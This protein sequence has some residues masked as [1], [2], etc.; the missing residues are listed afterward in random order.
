[1]RAIIH[2]QVQS[3]DK[4]AAIGGTALVCV[5]R[6]ICA[7][8]ISHTV[9]PDQAVAGHL[10]INSRGG[11][12]HRQMQSNDRVAAIGG[13][14]LVCIC[15]SICA[16][17]ISHTVMPGQAVA[18]HLLIYSRGSIVHRQVQSHDR[19]ATIGSSIG[20]CIYW[21]CRAGVIGH[22]V[23]PGQAIA[24]HLLVNACGSVVHRQDHCHHTVATTYCLYGGGLRACL[25]KFNPIPKIW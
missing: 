20:I 12:V 4:V 2:G 24:S 23:E 16:G 18:G 17:V 13:T 3:H 10:L 8:I 14:T 15:R 6:S 25:C 9:K 1:M 5:G 19:V 22:T 21:A 11:V 7:G